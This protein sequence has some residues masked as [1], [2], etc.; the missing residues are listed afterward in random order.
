MSDENLTPKE[1][2]IQRLLR[3]D[4]ITEDEAAILLKEPDP[5]VVKEIQFIPLP[6]PVSPLPP[7]G[8][9]PTTPISP[10]SPF[11]PKPNPW[12]NP[13]KQ[14]DWINDELQRRIDHAE[15]CQCNPK[16]GGSGMCG[17]VLASPVIYSSSSTSNTTS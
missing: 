1:K 15:R 7:I 12:P 14:N 2:I 13:F 4:Q 8:P 9:I 10:L 3:A 11:Q 16:N 17:C 5:K 6:R